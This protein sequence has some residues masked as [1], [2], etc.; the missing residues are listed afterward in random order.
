[1]AVLFELEAE[2][3]RMGLWEKQMPTTSALTSTLP[4]CADT[5]RIEQW[6]QW[7]FIPQIRALIHQESS[8]PLKCEIYPYALEFFQENNADTRS[9]L[10][11]IQQI[12]RVTSHP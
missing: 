10:Q 2:L 6:L 5:L 12:D 3:R 7:V 4:F 9:L 11:L 1:M 8:L